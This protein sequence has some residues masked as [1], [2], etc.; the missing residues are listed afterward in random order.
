MRRKLPFLA[1]ALSMVLASACSSPF[2]PR[3]DGDE[4]PSDS[5]GLCGVVGG[6]QTRN[7]TTARDEEEEE[8]EEPLN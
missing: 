5:T 1:L 2:G 4:D 3:R 7:L 8:C 6:S